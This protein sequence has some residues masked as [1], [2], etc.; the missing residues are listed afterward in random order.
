MMNMRARKWGKPSKV[1][2]LEAMIWRSKVIAMMG[3][4]DHWEIHEHNERRGRAVIT[5]L[6][7]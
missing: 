3:G 6:P 2:I 4:T 5:C 7:K 1:D